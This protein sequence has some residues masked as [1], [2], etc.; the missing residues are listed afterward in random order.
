MIVSA[1]VSQPG[2]FE[3]LVSVDCA[4]PVSSL[5]SFKVMRRPRTGMRRGEIH[6]LKWK[7]VDFEYRHILVREFFV[8]GQ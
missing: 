2:T 1:F 4:I 7:Y 3:I 8:S 6:G 5:T